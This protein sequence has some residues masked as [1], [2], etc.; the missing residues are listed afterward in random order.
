M[1]QSKGIAGMALIAMELSAK[2][3]VESVDWSVDSSNWKIQHPETQ[4]TQIGYVMLWY[5]MCI[6]IQLIQILCMQVICPRHILGF[7]R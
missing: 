4:V 3:P 7:G 2:L 6:V 1:A 5:V